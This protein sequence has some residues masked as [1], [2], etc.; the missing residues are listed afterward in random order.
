MS[1]GPIMATYKQI[2]AWVKDK[3]GF[4]VKTCWIAHVKEMCGLRLKNAPNRARG[5]VRKNPCPRDKV[6]SIKEALK[7][8]NMI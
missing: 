2:Q 4:S 1:A 3:H 5:I 8:F 7:H 6:E